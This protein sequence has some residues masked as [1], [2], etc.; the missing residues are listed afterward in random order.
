MA[1][2][3]CDVLGVSSAVADRLL[4]ANGGSVEAAIAAFLDRG[5][6]GVPGPAQ[7]PVRWTWRSTAGLQDYSPE[8]SAVLERVYQSNPS[9][10]GDIWLP[11]LPYT[12][13][14][15]FHPEWVQVN[16]K[17]GNKRAVARHDG[18]GPP[19]PPPA[20]PVPVAV[21]VA[22][23]AAPSVSMHQAL[24]SGIRGFRGGY[25]HQEGAPPPPRPRL[26]E[27][28]LQAVL[29]IVQAVD[30]RVEALEKK[31]K[32]PSEYTAAG[33]ISPAE[34]SAVDLVYQE[35]VYLFCQE[36]PKRK[37]GFDCGDEAY[38][39]I[40]FDGRVPAYN[41]NVQGGSIWSRKMLS[42]AGL[43]NL[44][45]RGPEI[46][47]EMI[48]THFSSDY[49]AYPPRE[50]L[51]K[52]KFYTGNVVDLDTV[53]L[54]CSDRTVMHCVNEMNRKE[55]CPSGYTQQYTSTGQFGRS[56]QATEMAVHTA[57]T[58]I[59]GFVER[60]GFSRQEML[61]RRLVI[62][63]RSDVHVA[64][65]SHDRGCHAIWHYTNVGQDSFHANVPMMSDV[66]GALL[67]AP[68]HAAAALARVLVMFKGAE[69]DKWIDAFMEECIADSCFNMKWKAIEE[70]CAGLGE[71]GSVDNV[72]ASTM[73]QH[74]QEFGKLYDAGYDEKEERRREVELYLALTRGV[75]GRAADGRLCEISRADVEAYLARV[76]ATMS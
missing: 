67:R 32:N 55:G 56:R 14:F 19:A 39:C 9:H 74:Q 53:V 43:R 1:S 75:R 18:S 62:E 45:K 69:R 10:N 72:L 60:F 3:V 54:R 13:R 5:D 35:M 73:E 42:V 7:P 24:M 33:L 23:P 25:R 34:C 21:P 51:N 27:D 26:T 12:Y 6:P 29:T 49:G 4:A 58:A 31:E 46:F 2:T 57:E 66:Y 59:Q 47:D 65:S 15:V 76:D 50:G 71:L 36:A 20:P 41:A 28:D 68:F 17:T 38:Q 63:N 11:G 70:F 30:K 16:N 8:A 37:F 61:K 48:K 22:A 64:T 44:V 40:P 52:M